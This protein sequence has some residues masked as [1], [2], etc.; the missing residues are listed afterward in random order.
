MKTY[1]TEPE[2]IFFL[3]TIY[4]NLEKKYLPAL[5]RKNEDFVASFLWKAG[6]KVVFHQVIIIRKTA[7]T[8]KLGLV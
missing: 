5:G 8:Q 7:I 6:M 4:R 1:L 3:E 2:F